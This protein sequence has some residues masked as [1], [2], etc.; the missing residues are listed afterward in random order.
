MLCCCAALVHEMEL[1]SAFT[2]RVHRLARGEYL[3]P[4]IWNSEPN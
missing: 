3:P 2:S 4:R 1:D